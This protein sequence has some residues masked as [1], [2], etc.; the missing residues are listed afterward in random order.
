MGRPK[1]H[2]EDLVVSFIRLPLSLRTRL[3]EAAEEREVSMNRLV[4]SAV[5]RYLDDLPPLGPA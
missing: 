4:E 1:L 5:A 3:Q 2:D